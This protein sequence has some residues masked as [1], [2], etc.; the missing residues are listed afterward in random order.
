ME[1]LKFG[2]M[3][4]GKIAAKFAD[5]VCISGR[6]EVVA[7]ASKSLERAREFAEKNE[8]PHYCGYGELLARED[9]D[10]IYIATTHNF[11]Y[12]NIKA[13][14]NAGKNVL[15]EKPM[16]LTEKDARE[17]FDLAQ[18]KGLFLMEAMWSRFLPSLQAAKEWITEGKIG[19]LRAISGAIGFVGNGD[20]SSRLMDPALAGGALYDIGVYAVEIASFLAGE[21]IVGV[22]GSVRRD[23]R[24]GVDVADSFILNFETFD[25]A[26][27]CALSSNVKEYMVVNGENG[28][29][30]LPHSHTGGDCFLYDKKRL[31]A[32]RFISEFPGN[33]GFVCE[34]EEVCDCI[35]SGKTVS[36]IMP[37]AAT[38]EC[39]RVFDAL[40]NQKLTGA[41]NV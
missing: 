38:I 41:Q 4:A 12:E 18:S 10:L 9:I 33:N 24:T 11:H 21:K 29:I 13:C 1:K 14:L 19:K 26:L 28:Y 15:C 22:T 17:L 30:E 25:A 27:Q 40:L 6:A 20:V 2:I 16:V 5:A 34:V 7:V 39:A 8:I 35:S 37:P 23:E 3:G 31:P 36:E 32:A